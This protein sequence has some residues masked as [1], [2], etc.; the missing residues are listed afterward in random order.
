LLNIRT[1]AAESRKKKHET[2][3]ER[4]FAFWT[5]NDGFDAV[6]VSVEIDAVKAAE[7]RRA[8]NPAIRDR[9][10]RVSLEDPEAEEPARQG[11]PVDSENLG[12]L[13]VSA[14]YYHRLRERL[15]QQDKEI[16]HLKGTMH[17]LGSGISQLRDELRSTMQQVM[18]QTYDISA[19]IDRVEATVK[20]FFRTVAQHIKRIRRG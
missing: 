13:L 6:A 19:K 14:E 3:V 5:D 17:E 7:A 2:V 9:Y 1:E 10:A 11:V 15:E 8:D 20:P 16:A 4:F 12:L 18:Y